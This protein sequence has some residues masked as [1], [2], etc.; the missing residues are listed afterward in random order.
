M[1]QQ[2]LEI[3]RNAMRFCAYR[4]RAS[5]EVMDKMMTWEVPVH[6][7][8]KLIKHLEE[9][10][11]LNDERFATSYANGKLRYNQWGKNKIRQGLKV[12]RITNETIDI[13]LKSID[14]EEYEKIA[15]DLIVIK[16]RSRKAK[17][18]FDLRKKIADYLVRKGFEGG[19]VWDWIKE[20]IPD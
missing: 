5:S 6:T 8:K 18:V 10:N 16:Q 11:F 9:E 12:K 13:A 4:E 1:K 2:E 17:N 3:L 15:K 20:M 19:L 14:L 7:A